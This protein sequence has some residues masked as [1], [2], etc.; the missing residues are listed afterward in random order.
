MAPPTQ[1]APH[2][3]GC[4]RLSTAPEGRIINEEALVRGCSGPLAGC[5]HRVFVQ[6][7]GR[8]RSPILK[9]PNAWLN[10][11]LRTP[12]T[13]RGPGV[14]SFGGCQLLVDSS[15]Q[16]GVCR[17]Q[18][19]LGSAVTVPE[20]RHC[21]SSSTWRTPWAPLARRMCATERSAPG[22]GALPWRGSSPHNTRL[23][24]SAFAVALWSTALDSTSTSSMLGVLARDRG[25]RDSSSRAHPK[26][27]D[28]K[29]ADPS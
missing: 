20:L 29:H 13:V 27:G 22:R 24:T 15:C 16:R 19:K 18:S 26:K 12:S 1:L 7:A 4:S 3:K 17:S 14:G 28:L 6:G 5:R 11:H 2:E 10:P 21:D 9:L 23:L 25:H 8:R